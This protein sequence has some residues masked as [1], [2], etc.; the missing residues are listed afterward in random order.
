[1][2]IQNV[3]LTRDGDVA[4]GCVVDV[5]PIQRVRDLRH[6]VQLDVHELVHQRPVLEV[7]QDG[8]VLADGH[9]LGG[10]G[11]GDEVMEYCMNGSENNDA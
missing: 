4:G 11:R 3:G 1:M 9:T 5:A 6:L 2:Q 7:Q 8:G 10:G